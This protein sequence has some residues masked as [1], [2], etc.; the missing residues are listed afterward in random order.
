MTKALRAGAIYFALVFAA[1]F[2]FG[3]L[4]TLWL[5][6]LLGPTLAVGLELPLILTVAWLACARLLGR[7]PLSRGQAAL[8]GA[9]AF[10]LLLAAEAGLSIVLAGRSLREHLALY[11]EAPQLLG[12]AGQLAFAGFP[13]AQAWRASPP[14]P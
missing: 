11:V 1:G 6:P 12:L 13:L 14:R 2:A 7:C 10:G 9:T 3:V 5:A 4:R 8:M